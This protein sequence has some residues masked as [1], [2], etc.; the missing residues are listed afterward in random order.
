MSTLTYNGVTIGL[1]KTL[2]MSHEPV[3]AEDGSYMYTR[4]TIEV[5]GIVSGPPATSQNPTPTAPPTNTTLAGPISDVQEYIRHALLMERC[6]LVYDVGDRPRPLIVAPGLDGNGVPLPSDAANG[7]IPN[8]LHITRL[9][10]ITTFHVRYSVTCHLRACPGYAGNGPP[11]LILNHYEQT[12]SIDGVTFLTTVVTEGE[13]TFRTDVLAQSQQVPDHYRDVLLPA[14]PK[15]F[16]RMQVHIRAA[17]TGNAL[18]YTVVDQERFYDLGDTGPSGTNSNITDIKAEYCVAS[19]GVAGAPVSMVTAH[20]MS[21]TIFGSKAASFWTLTKS[22]FVLAQTKLPIGDPTRGHLT[23]IAIRQVL[24]EKAVSLQATMLLNQQAAGPIPGIDARGL[25][26]DN[27]FQPRGGLNPPFPTR[28]GTAGS[29]T[30]EAMASAWKA[31]CSPPLKPYEGKVAPTSGADAYSSETGPI[32]KVTVTDNLP[33]KPRRYSTQQVKAPYTEYKVEIVLQT[34]SGV[35]AMPNSGLGAATPSSTFVGPADTPPDQEFITVARPSQ[36]KI[37]T[38]TAERIGAV[39]AAPSPTPLDPNLVLIDS[40][41]IQMAEPNLLP[42]GVTVAYR[43][44]GKY[45]Y[46]LKRN[47]KALDPLNFPIPPWMSYSYGQLAMQPTD[48]TAGIVGGLS[49]AGS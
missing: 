40:G 21:V 31:A 36:R 20:T 17:R 10:G 9:D 19:T 3:R 37:V 28:G 27:T 33:T 8:G 44:A 48:F 6:Q 24:H 26:Q 14:T 41:H 5:E 18:Q 25:Q 35:L 30:N 23:Q 16:K 42:D 29:Y 1:T 13:A 38:F 22:C 4:V 15:G 34:D 47:R 12:H 49:V 7:P 11:A 46:G 2:G 45:V 39:P 32:V 43:I